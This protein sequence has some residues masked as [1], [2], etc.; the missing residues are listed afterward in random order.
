VTTDLVTYDHPQARQVARMRELTHAPAPERF[1]AYV[2]P[3][4]MSGCWL[5]L[6]AVTPRGYGVFAE[7]HSRSVRAHRYAWELRNGPIPEAKIVCHK[8][9]NPPCV[10]PRHLFVGTH[11][12]NSDDKMR[13]GRYVPP[14]A[15]VK[16]TDAQVVE[17]R[18]LLHAGQLS[19][20]KIALQFDI[21]R[22]AINDIKH[23]YSWSGR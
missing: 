11:A 12:D 14:R 5:W 23:G 19:Q 6:G 16:L 10:N 2:M 22:S 4:P 9:D 1:A 18:T 21:S 15:N 3:E 20:Y 17:I 8:C 7:T 13:K